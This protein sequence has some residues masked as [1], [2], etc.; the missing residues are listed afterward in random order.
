MLYI[1]EY[2]MAQLMPY[3]VLKEHKSST[4]EIVEWHFKWIIQ[5]LKR[6]IILRPNF[7]DPHMIKISVVIFKKVFY[8]VYRAIRDYPTQFGISCEANKK[9]TIVKGY[10]IKFTHIAALRFHLKQLSGVEE[11]D[12]YFQRKFQHGERAKLTV[13][14]EE[15]AV[16]EYK[17]STDTLNIRIKYSVVNKYG[18]AYSV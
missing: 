18:I 15:P 5:S 11:V 12:D 6:K 1:L 2:D 8:Q 3:K 10:V 7:R 13:T 16:F 17:V 4:F 9:G 14:E